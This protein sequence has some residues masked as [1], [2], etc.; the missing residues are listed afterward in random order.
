MGSGVAPSFAWFD[1]GSCYLGSMESHDGTLY[2][3]IGKDHRMQFVWL[4]SIHQP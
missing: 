2:S 4:G 3:Y 1:L